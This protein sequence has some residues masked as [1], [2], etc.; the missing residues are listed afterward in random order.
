VQK[1]QNSTNGTVSGGAQKLTFVANADS[2]ACPDC[3]SITV[4]SGACYK[5]MNCGSTTGCG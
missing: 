2:P 5:C 3:G 1:P 4:R